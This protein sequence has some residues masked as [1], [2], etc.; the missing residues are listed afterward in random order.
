[1]IQDAVMWMFVLSVMCVAVGVIFVLII[2]CMSVGHMQNGYGLRDAVKL[3][4]MEF[5]GDIQG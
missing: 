2:F 3:S 4:L 1:M 5:D